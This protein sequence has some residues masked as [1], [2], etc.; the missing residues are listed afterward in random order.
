MLPGQ[1]R[2]ARLASATLNELRLMEGLVVNAENGARGPAGR[3][4]R[5]EDSLRRL[6]SVIVAYSG[7]VDS[8]YLAYAAHRVLGERML[9][10]IADSAS[11]ARSHYRDAVEFARQQAIPLRTVE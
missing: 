4:Q 6:G 5:L 11:L 1:C 8:A 9:A 3:R 2:Q 10:I 7:G